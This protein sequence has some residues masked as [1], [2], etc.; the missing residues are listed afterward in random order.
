MM[1]FDAP[2][3]RCCGPS[4]GT[5]RHKKHHLIFSFMKSHVNFSKALGA[6]GLFVMLM[7]SAAC[8][9]KK[10]ATEETGHASRG[11]ASPKTDLH[12]AVVTG[13]LEVVRQHIA[14]GTDLNTKEPYGGSSPLISAAVFGKSEIAKALIDAGADINLQN[15]DG[16]T[17]LHC[18]AFFCRPE[19]VKMLLDK[20][21]DKTL[22]NKYNATAYENVSGPFQEVKSVYDMILQALAPMGLVLDYAYVEKTRPVIAAM[23]K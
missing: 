14:A 6:I 4:P 23:L 21:A 3:L 5:L 16:S 17:A 12:T 9:Q 10:G 8:Q 1:L 22:K 11:M 2:V 15:N 18:A 7:T 20:H 13:N 19:I